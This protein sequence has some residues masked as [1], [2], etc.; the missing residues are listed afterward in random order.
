[1]NNIAWSPLL[2]ATGQTLYMVVISGMLS[3]VL[4]LFCGITLFITSPGQ[5]FHAPIVNRISATLINIVRSVPF[6]ILM[7]SIIP[8]TRL[9]VGTSIGTNAA[10]VPL[11]LAAIPFFA[12]V[13]E[14]ALQEVPKGLIEAAFAMGAHTHQIIFK[15]LIPESLPALIRGAS[16]TIISLIGYSAMAGAV[17]GGGLGEL[18]ISYGYQRFDLSVMLET[19][20]ILIVLVQGVQYLGDVLAKRRQIKLPLIMSL[21]LFMICLL[22]PWVFASKQDLQETLKVGI[23]TGPQQEVMQVVKKI[24]QQRYHLNLTLVTFDDYVLP[25]TALENGNIDANIFQHVP[26]LNE[27]I[28]ERHLHLVPMGKTFV[29]P[30]GIYSKKLKDIKQLEPG[31]LVAIPND[32][33]NEGRA[34]LIL[35]KAGFIRLKP[36]GSLLATPN[37]VVSNPENLHFEALDAAQLPRVLN[38]AALVA[39]TND[40]IKLA[41]L[42]SDQALLHEGSD[43][44]YANVVVVRQKDHDKAVYQKLLAAVQSAEAKAET[45][46]LFPHGGAIAAW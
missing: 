9:L 7:I 43:S 32:P 13:S 12:R 17:G 2:L 30:M 18:A 24:A 46:K 33:S 26:Y 27:Q 8:L 41:G 6:I 1:M 16:L 31:A 39:L 44:P 4:G 22:T 28:K 19:V 38:D 3:I 11:T 21:V 23:T 42:S 5:F 35:Q 34:L 29:Y 36:G 45:E 14:S 37:D 25:N 15:V 40:Y 10:L 20:I